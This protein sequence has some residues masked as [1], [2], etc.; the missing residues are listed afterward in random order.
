[1]KEEEKRIAEEQ[2]SKNLILEDSICYDDDEDAIPIANLTRFT[3]LR[4][5]DNYSYKCGDPFMITYSQRESEGRSRNV[6]IVPL[7]IIT[8]PLEASND[9]F[10][11]FFESNDDIYFK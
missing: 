5:P 1:M 9:P 6:V 3:E 7:M 2:A 11:G 8:P 4:S 10:N